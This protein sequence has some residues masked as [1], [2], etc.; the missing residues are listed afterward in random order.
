MYYTLHFKI[1]L[2]FLTDL[3]TEFTS[4]WGSGKIMSIHISPQKVRG[5][6]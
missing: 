6:E 5:F 1:Q 2:H 3:G 4:E